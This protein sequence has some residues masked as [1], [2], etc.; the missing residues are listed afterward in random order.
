M[1]HA[2]IARHRIY[3]DD[4]QW[5]ESIVTNTQWMAPV[6]PPSILFSALAA[7][8]RGAG[9]S[10][11]RLLLDLHSGRIG[12]ALGVWIVDATGILVLILAASGL[13]IWTMRDR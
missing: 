9:L 11:E 8:Y 4:L 10:V 1:V 6:T 12:G 7:E 2:A 13:W 3:L 5:Q